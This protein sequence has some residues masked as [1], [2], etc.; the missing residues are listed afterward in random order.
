MSGTLAHGQDATA[1]AVTRLDQ[2]E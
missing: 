2:K 1:Q